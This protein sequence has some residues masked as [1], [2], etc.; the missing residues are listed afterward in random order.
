MDHSALTLTGSEI[1]FVHTKDDETGQKGLYIT[2]SLWDQLSLSEDITLVSSS[3][4]LFIAGSN[5]TFD[6]SAAGSLSIDAARIAGLN[7]AD[8]SLTA[9]SI[10]LSNSGAA[11]TASVSTND[12]Q[13]AF[14]SNT[15]TVG[16]GDILF[17][18]FR[19][20]SLNSKGDLAL[21][22][23]GSL[24]TGNADLQI[25]AARI[26]TESGLSSD[27]AYQSANFLIIAGTGKDDLNPAYSI[28][29]TSPA[30]G[31]PGSTSVPGGTLEFAA[32]RIEIGTV[33]QVDGGT[34]KLTTAGAQG[35]DGI[36]LGDGAALLAQGTDDAPGGSVVLGTDFVD[37]SGNLQSGSIVLAEGSLIDVSAGTQGD[38]GFISL[39]APVNGVTIE[40]ALLGAARGGVG[41]SFSLDTNRIGDNGDISSLND[42]L[43]TKLD[44]NGDLVSGGFTG[45]LDIRARNGD[46]LIASGTTI[47]SHDFTMTA[48]GG[49]IDVAGKI[50]AASET[51]GGQVGLY[52]ADDLTLQE[53]GVIDVRGTKGNADGGSVLLSS[54]AGF[55]NLDQDSFI[56][57]SGSGA[58][59]GG[60]VHL[61]ALRTPDETDVQINLNGT[62]DGVSAVYAEA[63]RVYDNISTIQASPS[64][65]VG[66]TDASEPE[67]TDTSIG[68]IS[69]WQEDTDAYMTNAD[70]IEARLA[71]GLSDKFHLL[72]GIEVRNKGDITLGADW[73]LSARSDPEDPS[74]AFIWRYGSDNNLP[75]VLTLRAGGNLN[76]SNNLVDHPTDRNSL[77]AS[78][79]RGSWAFNLTAGADMASADYMSV[80][81][82][83]SGN[84]IIADQKL[85]Y[86]ESA[87]IRFA[88]SGN[89]LIGRGQETGPGYMINSSMYYN[90]ACFN[91]SIEGNVGKDLEINGGAIQT[92][93]GDIYISV[94]GDLDLT[95]AMVQGID[96]F[97]AI[98]T[99]GWSE[100]ISQYATYAGGGDIMLDVGGNVGKKISEGR[101]TTAAATIN[102]QWDYV[103]GT[104]ASGF[105]WSA[106][107]GVRSPQTVTTGLAT[108][109]G[110]DLVVRTG[111]NFLAQAGTF[112][113]NDEG[114][115]I[116]YSGENIA[117]RFLNAKGRAEIH[118][119]GD[120]GTEDNRQV[121][122]AF[123]SRIDLTAQR[124]IEL[125]A[126]I[127]PYVVA[128]STAVRDQDFYK[129]KSFSI[130]YSEDSSVSLKAGGD[131]I[132]GGQDPFHDPTNNH[133][134]EIM[135]PTLNIEAGG[136]ILLTQ[137]LALLPT[138][139]GNLRLIAG[140]SIDGQYID[141]QQHSQRA[142]IFVS[143][144]SP[145]DVYG[146]NADPS[147]INNLFLRTLHASTPVH[148]GDSTPVEVYA[149]QDIQ[150][151]KLFLPKRAEITAENG[152]VRDIFYYG[153]NIN[154]DDLSEI[155]AIKGDILFS[156]RVTSGASSNDDT[157]MVQAGPGSLFLQAGGSVTLGTSMGIQTVGSALNPILGSK[158]SD[159]IILSGYDIEMTA[160]DAGTFFDMIRKAGTDY[161]TLMASGE[162]D[163]A[164]QIIDQIRTET[165][166]P[167]L[168]SP[169]GNGD[170]DMTTSQ[171]STAY[172]KDN[173]YIITS[174]KL[175][176]G[177]STFFSSETDVQKTGIFTAGG[178]GINIFANGDINVNESRV[179]TFFGGD[180]T[181]WSD[182]GNINAGRGSKT[183]V[184]ASPPRLVPQY[185]ANGNNIIGYTVLFTPP[186]VGSGIRAVT[187]DP[188]GAAGPLQA[189]S[190]G[191]IYLFASKGTIDAGEAGISGGKVV[192][193]ATEIL[194]VGNIS[195]T[196]G[197][198]GVPTATVGA[199]G[200]GS[201]SGAGTLVQ[202]SQLMAEASGIAATTAAQASQ[203]IDDIMT[204]WLDVRIINY[205]TDDSSDE[206]SN[207]QKKE[208]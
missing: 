150:N 187:F 121:V 31:Q 167:L 32:R 99:T 166:D 61:R 110:G 138:P 11:S 109:G 113:R 59:R 4:L 60:T 82:T 185:D 101:W 37:G 158:G 141:S 201:L 112:G 76:I 27:G 177:R 57:A 174:G 48:D 54:A 71:G 51:C 182:S 34:I 53:D 161:S 175:D 93:T 180:L 111:G 17:G 92:A 83:G 43:S 10:H 197:S 163:Q 191:D 29:M 97:G 26:T 178:G 143:D 164:E 148:T 20:I 203:L 160:A 63:V 44:E 72:P 149:G 24:A 28:T 155:R 94:G 75:G 133:A 205:V 3:D 39:S 30:D 189:P 186:A 207:D 47:E 5:V 8:V 77:T 70:A 183:E 2:D 147:L 165:I 88:S 81:R 41:G 12:S 55:V 13:I 79:L 87:S 154:A 23:E 69:D 127:N 204:R 151:L 35:A 196:N 115:L 18:G 202:S 78:D 117:G 122:E 103:T 139:T 192:L 45:S 105:T 52:A 137:D 156:A 171:I 91:G 56:Y 194:N 119:M 116:I 120:F 126:V 146:D 179:M 118:A 140:G 16:S 125:A 90:L 67:A 128:I 36:Y 19:T 200:I 181:V 184:N 21:K 68:Y 40:G 173:I 6:L 14:N 172:G 96:T 46:L 142:Q 123:D 98:R 15:I 108:M 107:Y 193:G 62:I 66:E 188:D 135:P 159:L 89:T 132:Y 153:Q 42:R 1:F 162:K 176:V 95:N 130:G 134:E 136:D 198:I 22:G 145:E 170:I 157:G 206:N 38:A 73:D 74:T 100:S 85:V 169:S 104:A 114:D 144:L 33:V 106:S 7:A 129:L 65:A 9:P 152:D 58:G 80:S 190:P 86:T 131:V 124:N 199:S 208:E 84:L 64:V 25:S 49:N 50:L 102:N 168:G 195:F